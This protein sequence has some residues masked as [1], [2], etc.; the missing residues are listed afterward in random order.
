MSAF[1]LKRTFVASVCHGA[2]S[3]L[4]VL[5]GVKAGPCG[6]LTFIAG[7]MRSAVDQGIIRQPV[8]NGVPR[9]R[10]A[11]SIGAR[12]AQSGCNARG[13]CRCDRV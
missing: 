2:Q 3:P 5:S 1:G 6:D 10:I 13:K 8:S 4:A 11:K 7:E 9:G 12:F